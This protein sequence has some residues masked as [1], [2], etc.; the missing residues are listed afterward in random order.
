MNSKYNATEIAE[1]VT[2]ALRYAHKH[3]LD[4]NSQEDVKKI[5]EAL[6]PQPMNE[7]E[8][9]TFMSLLQDADTFMGM[10]ASKKTNQKINLPN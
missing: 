5:L 6:E 3:N 9:K 2:D 7:E 10:L 8:V 1:L 4:I